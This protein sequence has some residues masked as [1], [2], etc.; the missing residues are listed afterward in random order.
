MRSPNHVHPDSCAGGVWIRG[1][2]EMRLRCCQLRLNKP[3][4]LGDVETNVGIAIEKTQFIHQL[5]LL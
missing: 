1:Y 4:W 3:G 5:Q 2:M